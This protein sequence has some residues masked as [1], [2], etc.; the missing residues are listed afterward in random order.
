MFKSIVRILSLC[1]IAILSLSQAKTIQSIPLNQIGVEAAKQSGGKGLCVTEMWNGYRLESRLQALQAEV[2]MNGVKIMSTSKSEGGGDFTIKT[3]RIGRNT[4][5]QKL[6]AVADWMK[7]NDGVV[8]IGRKNI[9][10]EYSTSGDGIRQDFVITSRPKGQGKVLLDISFDGATV[11]AGNNND[12]MEVKFSCGR[13]LSYHTLKVTD[14]NGKNLASSFIKTKNNTVTIA[15]DDKGALYPV[16]IDPT[17]SDADW[18][19]ING[20][21]LGLNGTV[22]TIAID[23]SGNLYAGGSFNIAHDT[24]KKNIA[25]WD[26]STWSSFGR[27]MNG[28]VYILLFDNSNNLYAGGSFDTAGKI[29]ANR[30]AKWDGSTW[31]ALETGVSNAV[32]IIVIDSLNN[33]YVGGDFDTAGGIVANHIA[34]WDGSAWSAFGS[35]TSSAVYSIAIA[36]S[37]RFYVGGK[38]TTAGGAAANHI[39]KWDG[40]NWNALGSGTNKNVNAVYVDASGNLYAGGDFD[41]V[42]GVAINHIAQWDGTDWNALG[43]G[44]DSCVKTL[45]MDSAGNLYAGGYFDTAGNVAAK[46]IAKW[47]GGAWSALG[48]GRGG[49]VLTVAINKAGN[50]FAGGTFDSLNEKATYNIAK[51]NGNSWS[52]Y[53]SN[54]GL[55]LNGSVF[56]VAIDSSNNIYIGGSFKI[57]NNDSGLHYLVEW[58]G[59]KWCS[60]GSGINNPV[61]ALLF[62]KYWNLFAGGTFDS[63]GGIKTS[64]IAQWTNNT[65]KSLGSGIN[66]SVLALAIDSSGNLYAGGAFDTA[67]GI[68]AKHV[69]KWDGTNWS[70]LGGGLLNGN[71]LSLV[72]DKSTNLYAGGLFDTAGDVSAGHVAQWN[73]KTWLSLGTGFFGQ[74]SWTDRVAALAISSTGILYAAG[75]FTTADVGIAQW[76]GSSWSNLGKGIWSGEYMYYEIVYYGPGYEWVKRDSV[77]NYMFCVYS[78][79]VDNKDNLYAGGYFCHAGDVHAPGIAKWNG[80]VWSAVGS[81]TNDTV[82]ALAIKDSSIYAGGK[83]IRAGEKVSPYIAKCNLIGTG[84]DAKILG[85]GEKVFQLSPTYNTHTGTIKFQL[86]D[87]AQ[88]SYRIFSLSGRQIFQ[89]SENMGAGSHSMRINTGRAARGMYIVNFKA[90]NESMRF[91][92]AVEK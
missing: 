61:K 15:V 33:L 73:G 40:K 55:F 59:S 36:D 88:V 43:K 18:Q 77:Y 75:N 27:G 62:D 69:A 28:D 87:Q 21:V 71:C 45:S 11:K 10:E 3:S 80:N 5:M 22:Y 89:A 42:A 7:Q 56:A 82:Y 53:S 6:D 30:I 74:I 92:L 44:M 70:A 49:S 86:K 13:A 16:S 90:G 57:Y 50:V 41:T 63:A 12:G 46:H 2:T 9:I 34:K 58:N 60:L 81:G 35:G 38:F 79:S 4:S 20:Q 48:E 1:I 31:S 76:N 14:A 24:T 23:S 52:A 85:K 32:K 64:K 68:E 78:L 84:P 54:D 66:D 91:K 19:S 29:A 67:G 72:C 83:F 26:G 47:Y 8:R 51:W 39:A 65:W 37:K 17:I 25:K